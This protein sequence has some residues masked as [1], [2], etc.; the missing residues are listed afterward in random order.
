MTGYILDITI[1]ISAF[2][3]IFEIESLM[4]SNEAEIFENVS[5]FQKPSLLFQKLSHWFR[6]SIVIF[7]F[8][9]LM[10]R[11]RHLWLRAAQMQ[12]PAVVFIQ[13]NYLSASF[14]SSWIWQTIVRYACNLC[15]TVLYHECYLVSIFCMKIV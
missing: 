2:N 8:A 9:S 10:F 11:K 15:F 14:P 3:F 5:S 6:K 12:W 4:S 7:H 1:Y 13:R